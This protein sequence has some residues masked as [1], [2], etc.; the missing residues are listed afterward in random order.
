MAE[1]LEFVRE[2]HF[3]IVVTQASQTGKREYVV[4]R[5]VS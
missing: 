1:A 3:H 5:S 2:I 4:L